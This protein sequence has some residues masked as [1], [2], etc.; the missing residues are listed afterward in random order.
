MFVVCCREQIVAA[1]L[2]FASPQ[3]MDWLR[4]AIG[5]YMSGSHNGKASGNGKAHG[6][7]KKANA[8]TAI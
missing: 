1:M 5:E 3:N 8:Q 6:I 7:P 4:K 2:S